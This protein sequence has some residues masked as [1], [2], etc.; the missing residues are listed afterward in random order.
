MK[1]KALLPF[2]LR[3][4]VTGA[5]T[6]IACGQ[7]AVMDDTLGSQLISDGLA[8]EYTLISPTGSK[9][10]TENG[11]VDVTEYASAVVNVGTYTVTYDANGG[12]G[13]VDAVTVVAGNTVTL[14]DGTGITAPEDKTF[15]GWATESTAET[16]DVESPYKPTADV[17]LYAVYEDVTE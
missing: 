12:T 9:T 3:D 10:I 13:S 11:T 5:I 8:E 15:A 16:P 7:V 2:T 1:V 14:S 17:T 6:S 4:S